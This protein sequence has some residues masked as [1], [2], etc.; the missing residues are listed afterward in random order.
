MCLGIAGVDREDDS[1][2]V[3]AIMRRISPGSR[4]LVV[5]DALVA[6]EAG[7]PGAPGIVI[8]CGTGSIAYGRNAQGVAARAGGWGHIIGDEGSG[9]W[10]GQQAVQAVMRDAD[11][12]GPATSLTR[13]V[14]A[15]F[16]VPQRLKPRSHRLRSAH[17]EPKHCDARAGG[18]DGQRVGDAVASA[19]L[20][21]AADELALAAQVGRRSTAAARGIIPVRARRWRLSGR[22]RA[23][24]ID[25][26]RVFAI[27]H[28][29]PAVDLLSEEPA[30]GAVRL[31]L[32]EARGRSA[33]PEV[34]VKIRIFSSPRSGGARARARDR[35]TVSRKP[36]P[37]ARAAHGTHD[38]PAVPRARQRSVDPTQIDFSQATT[39]NLDEFLGLPAD[40]PRSYHAFMRRHLFDHVNLSRRR[41]HLLNGAARDVAGE[42]ARFERAIARAGGIDLMVLGLG[43]NGHI[44]FNEPDRSLVTRTH[45]TRL[46]RV[47]EARERLAVRSSDQR[48]PARGAVDGDGNDP[49]G[50]TD[51]AARHRRV[52]SRRGGT[53]ASAGD[54]TTRVPASFLQLHRDVEVWLDEAAASLMS[55]SCRSRGSTSSPIASRT[56]SCAALR[57]ESAFG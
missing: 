28:R 4:V 3:G 34:R 31:A 6:L 13:Q 1:R 20:E 8:I 7:A 54:M 21:R 47:N 14:L 12:R 40:D 44:G 53:R 15:H 16:D 30:L 33:H 51:C 57:R 38:H 2:I 29:L 45:R 56:K 46:Q 48:G 43:R 35:A 26:A 52:E 10:I 25:S 11:G 22:S 23:R 19:I 24:R 5:N 18:A 36:A 17:R 50:A 27:S 41:T 32:A 37:G 39:F 42:C 49:A 9:Y 55:S